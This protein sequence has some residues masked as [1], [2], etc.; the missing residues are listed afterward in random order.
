MVY[1][2]N[3]VEQ[4]VITPYLKTV[5]YHGEINVEVLGLSLT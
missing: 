4:S 5:Y 1:G 3:P 2:S